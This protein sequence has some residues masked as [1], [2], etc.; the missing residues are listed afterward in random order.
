M[1]R[2]KRANLPSALT[3]YHLAQSTGWVADKLQQQRLAVLATALKNPSYQGTMLFE[4]PWYPSVK[5]TAVHYFPF[6]CGESI[7]LATSQR[8]LAFSNQGNL[9][10]SYPNLALPPPAA[11]RGPWQAAPDWNRNTPI[12]LNVLYAA[13]S[14]QVVVAR[15]ITPDGTARLTGLAALDG[16]LLWSTSDQESL[17]RLSFQPSPALSG[18]Y[19][20][21]L[22]TDA[23]Q[24]GTLWLLALNVSTGGEMWR[25]LL[26]GEELGDFQRIVLHYTQ[27]SGIVIAEDQLVISPNVDCVMAA[28]RFT[29]KIRWMNANTGGNPPSGLPSGDT[30]E[31][32]HR[33]D[34]TP[35]VA[36]DKVIVAGQDGEAIRALDL[37]SG[38]QIWANGGGELP[39]YTLAGVAGNLAILAGVEIY[40]LD[41]RNGNVQWR[42]VPSPRGNSNVLPVVLNVNGQTTWTSR[43]PSRPHHRPTGHLRWQGLC[44]NDGRPARPLR[45]DRP[46]GGS[47][48]GP[49][50]G[51]ARC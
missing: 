27:P 19:V 2:R 9:L 12:R 8:V 45:P 41:C 31:M 26:G 37:A 38:R 50:T 16:R 25:T 13:S 24:P 49:A 34:N 20:Y 32:L 1:R 46:G 5:S 35:Y 42:Y 30:M 15:G 28:D 51:F 43:K 18:Q 47:A 14:P 29:G 33:Y 36:G 4:P 17:A 21:D 7:F 23:D 10:W 48:C 3:Y 44:S 40:A 11:A 22:A 39:S 6:A